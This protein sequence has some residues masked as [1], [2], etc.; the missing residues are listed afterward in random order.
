[1]EDDKLVRQATRTARRVILTAL[2]A[3]ALLLA[4]LGAERVHFL[5]VNRNATASISAATAIAG[6]LMLEDEILTG[7]ANLASATGQD[8]W[9]ARYDQHIPM[10]DAAIANALTMATDASGTRYQNSVKSANDS[11]V[12]LERRA[13]ELIHARDLVG[14]QAL[15]AG[16]AYAAQKRILA[17]GQ[18]R[19]VDEL[20]SDV[21]SSAT[22]LQR[23]S[24][25]VVFT[26]VL[27]AGLGFI[28]L[29]QK[30]NHDLHRSE[31]A[32]RTTQSE[33]TQMA[34]HD[35]LTGLP[36]RRYLNEQ[37]DRAI[38]R[39]AR[40]G[41][42][43]ATLV[44]DLDG[45]KPIND[46]FG[47][48]AG[49]LVLTTISQRLTAQVRKDE[50]ASRLGGDEFVVMLNRA[51]EDDGLLRAA[52][53]LISVVG[54]P[55]TLADE[56][57]VRVGASIGIALY[58]DDATDAEELVR[59]ADVAMYRAKEGGRGSVRF[60]KESMDAEVSER[61]L[62]EMDLRVSIATSQIV[63]FFQ[64]LIDLQTRRLTG[65]EALARW[66]HPK[67]GLLV[68]DRFISIA[69]DTRQIGAL[70]LS[71]LR[72]ALAEA[73]TWDDSLMLA[74]NIAPQLLEDDTLVERIV[75]MMEEVAFP[76]HRLEVEITESAFIRDMASASR[77]IHAFK[78]HGVSVALDDFGTG[79]S[80]LSH[81]SELPFDKI[82]IDRSFVQ[83][84][85][86][87]PQSAT[88]VNAIIGLGHSMHL[89][90][91]AEGIEDPDDETMLRDLGCISGQGFLYSKP[92][93]AEDVAAFV[94]QFKSQ[95]LTPVEAA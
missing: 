53:R 77:L 37:L 48:S 89:R 34:L 72:M 57:T 90:T 76:P 63:P 7:S 86:E 69:E 65:F 55:I 52:N 79:Y 36:N 27:L 26:L 88:I 56:S 41:Q 40:S 64:P 93:P 83:T 54:E 58:P 17:E 33:I 68:P 22:R 95:A 12:M 38:A 10:I 73:S 23:N 30:L 14:A 74:V 29:W 16:Q 87:R 1:M 13:F 47:H 94:A 21:A 39:H 51:G 75:R 62:L 91:T 28:G 3:T 92:V 32:F 24:W 5:Q 11:L 82:K 2:G 19:F 45:F 6:R 67:H 49:D 59:R 70:T 46:R 9:I 35:T 44:I 20:Q 60:F 15:L 84:M 50:V 81:L 8:R 78:A 4:A 66:H 25:M 43:F 61:A 31:D 71:V 42:P 18:K 80:S 85:R